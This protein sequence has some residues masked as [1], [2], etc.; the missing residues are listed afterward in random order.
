M[1]V[2]LQT[3]E[4]VEDQQCRAKGN[5]SRSVLD[6]IIMIPQNSIHLVGEEHA[7]EMVNKCELVTWQIHR[8]TNF[9]LNNLLRN[10]V[11][12]YNI[13]YRRLNKNSLTTWP[14]SNGIFYLTL[15]TEFLY[16]PR[17]GQ[18]P[19]LLS[20]FPVSSHYYYYSLVHNTNEDFSGAGIL[21]GFKIL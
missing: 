5:E 18:W 21:S 9:N 6:I 4:E 19:R 2:E 20:A 1:N 17:K 16:T 14:L 13:F 10:N 12:F 3:D 7:Q 11:I 15:C 8:K